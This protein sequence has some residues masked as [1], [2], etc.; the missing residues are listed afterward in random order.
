M[1]MKM[2]K[3]RISTIIA[4][5]AF[6]VAAICAAQGCSLF[7]K[8][9]EGGSQ[10]I[11]EDAVN[12]YTA[13]EGR[14]VETLTSFKDDGSVRMS[15]TLDYDRY[16]RIKTVD[17]Y[18]GRPANGNSYR[19]IFSYSDSYIAILMENP[20]NG[21]RSER[22]RAELDETGK[23]TDLENLSLEYDGINRLMGGTYISSYDNEETD[24]NVEWSQGNMTYIECMMSTSIRYT[25]Q[26]NNTNID[27]TA[28]VTNAYYILET[29]PI[30]MSM[31]FL[32]IF[33][34]WGKRNDNLPESE[35]YCTWD[36]PEIFEYEMN[37][38]GCPVRVG[39]WQITYLED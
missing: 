2:N 22:L 38:D 28:L 37:S 10:A 14:K 4:A 39:N 17:F 36:S 29:L 3:N 26:P 33:G 15:C 9:D 16:D 7:D 11:P 31:P 21:H 34:F 6:T 20:E 35:T 25:S 13:P 8:E 5:T 23:I 12:G 1:L 27:I 19:L 30:N 24:I 18:D 32:G